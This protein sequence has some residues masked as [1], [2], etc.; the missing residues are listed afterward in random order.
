MPIDPLKIV[1]QKPPTP[2]EY[3]AADEEYSQQVSRLKG[4][5][6]DDPT[7]GRLVH[8]GTW[9]V[10]TLDLP[11]LGEGVEVAIEN[12][13][14]EDPSDPPT[15]EAVAA[16]VQLRDRAA[17]V[18]RQIQVAAAEA[19][20]ARLPDLQDEFDNTDPIVPGLKKGV[21]P[22]PLVT[23]DE[24]WAKL[25]GPSVHV[26]DEEGETPMVIVDYHATW[27]DEHGLSLTFEDARL[28]GVE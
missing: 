5:T 27:D 25:D 14:A 6:H 22:E 4:Q 28:T 13:M 26:L 7:L 8:D 9:W 24:V 11:L 12:E 20:A 1:G 17:E 23:P 21:R 10:T 15:P 2:A 16:V 18:R 19:Y 3:V